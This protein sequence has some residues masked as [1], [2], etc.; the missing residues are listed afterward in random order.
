MEF[1][2]TIARLAVKKNQNLE[3]KEKILELLREWANAFHFEARL[4]IFWNTYQNLLSLG[5]AFP[6]AVE[7]AQ[8]PVFT[9]FASATVESEEQKEQERKKKKKAKSK[10]LSKKSAQG[11]YNSLSEV[12]YTRK[13]RCELVIVYRLLEQLRDGLL[14]KF[15]CHWFSPLQTCCDPFLCSIFAR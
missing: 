3:L 14:S 4:P 12:Q 11:S 15:Y 5:V 10:T 7:T 1:C 8:A 9:P 6:A 13:I 2:E